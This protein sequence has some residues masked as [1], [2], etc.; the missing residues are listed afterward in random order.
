MSSSFCSSLS[1]IPN[2][3]AAP[4]VGARDGGDVGRAVA[5]ADAAALVSLPSARRLAMSSALI[6]SSYGWIAS[7]A[8]LAAR[9]AAAGGGAGDGADDVTRGRLTCAEAVAETGTAS[10]MGSA[11]CS[12]TGSKTFEGSGS[13]TSGSG[14]AT[15]MIGSAC[16]APVGGGGG[17]AVAAFALPPTS[18]PPP[19]PPSGG[20]GGDKSTTGHPLTLVDR[21]AISCGRVEAAGPY[22]FLLISKSPNPLSAM[23]CDDQ[24]DQCGTCIAS[25]HGGCGKGRGGVEVVEGRRDR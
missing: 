23:A 17:G 12:T 18:A 20:D 25:A 15:A 7:A 16:A 22:C 9:S 14:S 10:T 8:A 4:G 11:A 24:C 5:A 13:R 21:V 3:S 2:V 19:P 6:G 1:S